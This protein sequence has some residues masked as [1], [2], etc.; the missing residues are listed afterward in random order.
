MK[1][2]AISITA[3]AIAFV[4]LASPTAQA[5]ERTT[6]VVQQ[7]KPILAN[8]SDPDFVPNST[9]HVLFF[10]ADLRNGRGNKI[11]EV[12][13]QVTTMDVTLDGAEEEDR[14]RELV[15]NLKRG[16]IVVL[17]ASQYAATKA[18][19]FANNNAPVTAVVVGGTG[20]YAGVRG[21]VTT[22]KRKNGTYTH[23]FTFMQ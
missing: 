7:D 2:I 3:L 12:I 15:F 18:P 16:Q 8:H 9:G 20:D 14:F 13:G 6:L 17:G 23:T 10:G 1:K 11:G 22:K 4:T 19:N 21:T 5:D